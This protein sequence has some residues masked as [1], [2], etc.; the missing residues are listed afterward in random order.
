MTRAYKEGKHDK[1]CGILEPDPQYEPG[2]KS[3]SDYV[4]GYLEAISPQVE[5]FRVG[6]DHHVHF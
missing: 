4:D 3:Y 6:G 1:Q 5:M 2:T